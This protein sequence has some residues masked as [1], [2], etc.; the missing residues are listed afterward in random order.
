[1]ED[2]KKSLM[3]AVRCGR[4]DGGESFSTAVDMLSGPLLLEYVELSAERT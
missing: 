4:M 2:E 1:M 3:R